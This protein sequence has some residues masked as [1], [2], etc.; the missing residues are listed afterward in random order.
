MSTETKK[1]NW[2]AIAGLIMGIIA[3]FTGS[4]GVAPILAIVFS[5]IGISKIQEHG[6]DG[7]I[8]AWVGLVL[9]ILYTIV[10]VANMY[11]VQ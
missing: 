8:S 7:K 4:L 3:I 6:G 9:G 2:F 1:N 11:K 5:S 10:F